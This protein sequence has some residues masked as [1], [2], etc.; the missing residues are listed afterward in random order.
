MMY[1]DFKWNRSQDIIDT[2]SCIYIEREKVTQ[3]SVPTRIPEETLFVLYCLWVK[4]NV[5]QPQYRT[6]VFRQ[7]SHRQL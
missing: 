6:S 1:V 4:V 2:I 5:V 3:Y 7:A